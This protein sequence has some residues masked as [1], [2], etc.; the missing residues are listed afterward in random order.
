MQ[1]AP[2]ITSATTGA[3]KHNRRRRPHRSA[4]V[5]KAI[6]LQSTC[7]TMTAVE[8]MKAH[9]FGA[10]IIIRVLFE[11]EERRAAGNASAEQA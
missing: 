8:Y 9:Q 2:S 6:E 7:S 5:D 10:Q 1:T 3:Y 11:R 4:L